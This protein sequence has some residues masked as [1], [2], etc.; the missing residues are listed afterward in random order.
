MRGITTFLALFSLTIASA[1]AQQ[2]PSGQPQGGG[3]QRPARDTAQAQPQGTAVIAGRVVAADTGRPIK[4]ARVMVSAG[5]RQARATTTDEQGRFRI[6]DL[7]GGS[8]TITASRT[9]FVDA[10]YGQRRPLQPGTAIQLADGQQ[11]ATIDLRLVRGGVITGRVLDEDGEP[12]ARALVTVQRYQYIRGERQLSAAGGGQSDDRGQYRVFGLPPGEYYVSADAGGLAQAFGRGLQQLAGAIGGGPDGRGGRA[13][14][15]GAPP[16]DDPEP[17]GY[18]PTYYPGVV[19]TAEATKITVGAGQE[20]SGMDFQV[21]LVATATISGIV[22]GADGGVPVL[23]VPQDGGGML[24]GQILRGSARAD[25]VFSIA[26]VPPGRYTAIARS[27]GGIFASGGD[28]LRV[29]TQSINV[30]GQNIAGVTIALQPAVTLSGNITI[31][32]SGT[33]APTDYSSFRIDV[34]DQDPLPFAGG[35]GGRGGGP[36]ASGGRA[37]TNGAFTVLNL[38]PGRHYVRVSGNGLWTLKSVSV[39]GRDVTDEAI[40]LRSGHDVDNV[41]I[42]M[43]DRSTEISGAVRDATGTDVA[44]MAVIAF[45]IDQQQWQP[46]SRSIQAVR[47]GQ[48][49]TYRLRGLPPGDYRII[50]TEDVEQGEWLDP[51]FL[52]RVL[53]SSEKIS[54]TDGEKKTHDLKP[55]G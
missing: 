51:A 1:V 38:L 32:S 39:A 47:T 31:E 26:N 19:S 2:P 15:F 11:I 7:M 50:A 36:N 34:P 20:V 8:Y 33:P 30:A 18:A 23:L 5:G 29:G 48:D 44:A 12:L 28:T 55:A 21:Q 14:F 42:V 10:V 43:T 52:E 37:D 40:E 3:G 22:V 27:G 35:S 17:V 16:P 53:P 41:T 4:R 9:G 49:G 46:H 6:T 13:G 24:R 25:G 54:L 45:S